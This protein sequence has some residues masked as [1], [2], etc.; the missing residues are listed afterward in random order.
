MNILQ[1]ARES[2]RCPPSLL[3][4]EQSG[5]AASEAFE[6]GLAKV[7]DANGM[8]GVGCR[9]LDLVDSTDARFLTLDLILIR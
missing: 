3:L 2:G 9:L 1:R 8:Y 7:L 5:D 6:S 4:A